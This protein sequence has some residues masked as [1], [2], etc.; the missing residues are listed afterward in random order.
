MHHARRAHRQLRKNEATHTVEKPEVS[1]A[2]GGCGAEALRMAM[3]ESQAG[4]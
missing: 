2:R 3:K 4:A 1:N